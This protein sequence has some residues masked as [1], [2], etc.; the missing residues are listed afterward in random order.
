MVSEKARISIVCQKYIGVHPYV[1][2]RDFHEMS[3][4][5]ARSEDYP[6]AEQSSSLAS[7]HY[8]L[9]HDDIARSYSFLSTF[10]EGE[11]GMKNSSKESSTFL[12]VVD[13]FLSNSTLKKHSN[14]SYLSVNREGVFKS[15][16]KYEKGISI[17]LLTSHHF[18]TF[19]GN[20][21]NVFFFSGLLLWA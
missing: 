18:L 13:S 7:S 5:I 15:F 17:I 3:W 12:S 21:R 8:R 6:R 2:L 10:S 16:S 9:L 19:V 1:K 11:R 4:R 14:N 20:W